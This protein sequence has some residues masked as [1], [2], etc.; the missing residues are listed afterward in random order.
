MTFNFKIKYNLFKKKN[1]N[2]VVFLYIGIYT[3]VKKGNYV[4][5]HKFMPKD[6]FSI[7]NFPQKTCHIIKILKILKFS[8]KITR[9]HFFINE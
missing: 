7:K 2:I 1:F 8:I 6:R 5:N 4:Y 3:K 9:H